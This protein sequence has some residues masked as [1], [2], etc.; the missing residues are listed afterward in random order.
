VALFTF[1][2]NSKR[3]K[4]ARGIFAITAVYAAIAVIIKFF[5]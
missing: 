5:G 1:F 4:T 2:V 3:D